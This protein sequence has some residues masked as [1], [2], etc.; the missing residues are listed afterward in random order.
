MSNTGGLCHVKCYVKYGGRLK[1][2]TGTGRM[3][4]FVRPAH[5]CI[6]LLFC[7]SLAV[8]SKQYASLG[9]SRVRRPSVGR[10]YKVSD[11]DLS[12]RHDIAQHMTERQIA[13]EIAVS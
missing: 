4:N 7:C 1:A 2:G 6:W 8:C 13:I 10:C 3:Q 5:E 11:R 12:E 9:Y